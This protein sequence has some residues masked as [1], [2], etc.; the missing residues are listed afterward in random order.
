MNW[1]IAAKLK[2]GISGETI[3]AV[4]A[5]LKSFS[6]GSCALEQIDGVAIVH[7]TDRRDFQLLREQFADL[8]EKEAAPF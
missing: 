8:V 3:E 1:Q 6:H 7:F 2:S 4:R 5:Y